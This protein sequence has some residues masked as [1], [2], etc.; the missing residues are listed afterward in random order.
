[1]DRVKPGVRQVFER[2]DLEG[3]KGMNGEAAVDEVEKRLKFFTENVSLP[4]CIT[5]W[6]LIV[7]CRQFL[8]FFGPPSPDKTH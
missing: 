7:R 1:M 3:P 8:H 2:F 4:V 5:S 6:M